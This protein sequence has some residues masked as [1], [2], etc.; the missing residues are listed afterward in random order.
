MTYTYI[1]QDQ[2]VNWTLG[3][4]FQRNLNQNTIIFIQEYLIEMAAIL[5]Q[6]RCL[7][8]LGKSCLMVKLIV[9]FILPFLKQQLPS[10]NY[11]SFCVCAQ[12][13][14]DAVTLQCCFSLAGHIHR[15]IPEYQPQKRWIWNEI[16]LFWHCKSCYSQSI[17]CCSEQSDPRSC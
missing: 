13:T 8:N 14:R 1:T 3:N 7:N 4:K 2:W 6:P 17:S 5:S 15:I 16:W 11:G 9:D 10:N 12:P